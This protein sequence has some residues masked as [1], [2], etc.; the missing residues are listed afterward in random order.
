MRE[1]ERPDRTFTPSTA[2]VSITKPYRQN[3]TTILTTRSN[4]KRHRRQSRFWCS[5]RSF[6]KGRLRVHG[7]YQNSAKFW[8]LFAKSY[9]SSPERENPRLGL[10]HNPG[11][12]TGVEVR[13]NVCLGGVDVAGDEKGGPGEEEQELVANFIMCGAKREGS[14]RAG[15][16]ILDSYSARNAAISSEFRP[17]A[18][19]SQLRKICCQRR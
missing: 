7:G 14:Y 19:V 2:L 15:R 3:K 18:A 17:L 1:G 16:S 4:C 11:G 10:I 9:R 8:D 13:E 5:R 6:A 12:V